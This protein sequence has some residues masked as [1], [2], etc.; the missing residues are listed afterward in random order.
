MSN[1]IAQYHL[2]HVSVLKPISVGLSPSNL[3]YLFVFIFFNFI[4][5]YFFYRASA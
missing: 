4:F 2:H 5:F 1:L 3:S